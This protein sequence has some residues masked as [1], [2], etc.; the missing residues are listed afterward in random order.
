MKIK[1]KKLKD[2]A[3]LPKM[4]RPGDAALDLYAVEDV[5]IKVDQRVVV[6][7]GIAIEIPDGYVG[8]VR[9]RTG[10]SFK[11]GLHTMAG[12]IDSNYRGDI[13]VLMINLGTEDY[14]IKAGDRIAQIMVHKI[15]NIELE[16]VGELSETERGE[17]R[18]ASSGY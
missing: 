6:A 11:H 14:Q 8:N 16:E 1:I 13:S 10:I 12:V 15:E 2:S 4:M 9:D 3:I 7:T 17:Q 18:F 5:V